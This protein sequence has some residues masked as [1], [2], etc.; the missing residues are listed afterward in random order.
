MDINL[1]DYKT[2]S[3]KL[4]LAQLDLGAAVIGATIFL[5]DLALAVC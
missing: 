5:L 4:M 2:N 3:I 1:F